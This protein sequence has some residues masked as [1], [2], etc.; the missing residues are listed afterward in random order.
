MKTSLLYRIEKLSPFT[1]RLQKCRKKARKCFSS[2]L[3]Q[4]KPKSNIKIMMAHHNKFLLL[5]GMKQ[6][7]Y[8][9][10][11]LISLKNSVRLFKV[12]VKKRKC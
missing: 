12:E 10:K 5:R 4:P 6:I 9:K 11:S 1:P 8:K 2:A 3:R 7:C